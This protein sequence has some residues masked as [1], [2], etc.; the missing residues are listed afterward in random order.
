MSGM[1]SSVYSFILLYKSIFQLSW[2]SKWEREGGE[3][4]ERKEKLIVKRWKKI[5]ATVHNHQFHIHH[6][7]MYSLYKDFTVF[8]PK[9]RFFIDSIFSIPCQLEVNF[10]H[11]HGKFD[12]QQVS[13]KK[14]NDWVNFAIVS[15]T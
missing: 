13:M 8:C 6:F 5:F 14:V 4:S 1:F 10:F 12:K 3:K 9:F 7:W 2:V 11:F 15:S